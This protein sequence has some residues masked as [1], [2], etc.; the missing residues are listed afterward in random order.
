MPNNSKS[1]WICNSCKEKLYKVNNVNI[2]TVQSGENTTSTLNPSIPSTTC[3]SSI[4]QNLCGG[5][6]GTVD[7]LSIR[8]SDAECDSNDDVQIMKVCRGNIDKTASLGNLIQ[9]EYDI[10]ESPNGWLDCTVIQEAHILL[11]QV[12]P[13]IKGFQ[14][15]TLGPARN[16]D[17]V[18]SEFVQILHTGNHHWVCTSS[19]GC[20]PGTV[21]LYDSLFHDIIANEVEE[22]LKDLMANKLTGINIVPVQQQ[23]NGSDCGVFSIAFATCIVY[24]R[25]P[26]MVTFDVP[27][28]RPHLSRCLKT[29]VLSPFPQT[30][31]DFQVKYCGMLV[32][33]E[34]PWLHATPDFM[35][36]CSCCGDGC[37]EVKCPYGIENG[38]FE[39]YI[40][41][42]TSCLEK[43]NGEL[44]LKKNH[45]YY[46]QVQQQLNITKLKYCD[47]V[48]FAFNV[49]NQPM[50]FQE[51]IYPDFN[52][53]ELLQ[54]KLTKFWR[55]C[56]LPEI[57]GRWYTRKYHTPSLVQV[58]VSGNDNM[59]CYCR[60]ATGEQTIT[61]SNPK[62][63][64]LKFHLSCLRSSDQVPKKWYCPTC[65]LLPDFKSNA[66]TRNAIEQDICKK[67]LSLDSVCICNSKPRP[68][69]R[70]LQCHSEECLNGKFFHL[71]CLKYKRMPN[72]SKS[73]WICNSCKEKLYK[74]NNVN[75]STVQSGENTTSTLNPSIPSTTCTS[76][77]P[78]NLCGGVDGTVDDLSIRGSDAECD[79]ND[80]VQIMK[81]CRGNIDKTAS[82]GN[83]IQAEY[84]I[85]ESPNGWLDCTVIQEAHILLK[86][87]NPMIKGFQRTTL[88]PARN[89]DVVTSEFVQILHTGNHHWVCTSSVGCLPGTV[90]LYD[91]LFHD[92]IANEVEE[93]LKDLMANKLTGIN[94]V[95][96]QQ[97]GN[98][99]DCGVFSIAFATCIVYGRD[100]G[101][102]TF[103]VPQMR[104]HLSRCLKTGVLSPFP[105][106]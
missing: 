71:H 17:V 1:T 44:R 10:I 30:H 84:D 87:V 3:T 32:D 36:S 67:A 45:Q 26:G 73:T 75:I 13:M 20:L 58:P 102:V 27:Q 65:R 41:K 42:K 53:W 68:G 88:G 96:V 39:T 64:Y 74:V 9:A 19:V 37:G 59:I 31:K 105:Q 83:L 34:H 72:N 46:Y 93:Q 104:P 63:P 14:R 61:C 86:Q 21:N 6:D 23:G 7:D 60:K 82:L 85:I 69:D 66:K 91:S 8:G 4:P 49:N 56:I 80:D 101:M 48:V 38:D 5:V 99:S 70:L 90:N 98:G 50:I 2:S 95:P 97:Q 94:I 103:D 52:L 15:T 57:L 16:F 25:D 12:N 62:C 11:K 78:Q 40:S 89:F 35:A 54:P 33:K 24:G 51:R 79:S 81:V 18:T 106:V 29:G 100:P 55:I 92:I 22:Q 76:S 77:I 47:F 28:M 43:V